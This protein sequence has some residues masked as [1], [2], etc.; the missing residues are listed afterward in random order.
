[1]IIFLKVTIESILQYLSWNMLKLFF[2][3]AVCQENTLTL[4]DQNELTVLA[5]DKSLPIKLQTIVL[6]G[7]QAKKEKKC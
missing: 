2:S 5:Y 6:S 4:G 7:N 3:H 1:M